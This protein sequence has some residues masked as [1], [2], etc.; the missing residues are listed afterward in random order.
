METYEP[1]K[2]LAKLEKETDT[3]FSV[4]KRDC[5]EPL[6]RAWRQVY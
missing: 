4:I 2:E 5:A 1:A 6:N 3:Q